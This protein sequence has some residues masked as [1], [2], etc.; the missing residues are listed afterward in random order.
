MSLFQ[1]SS[2][3]PIQIASVPFVHVP[4]V[5]GIT[6]CP[7]KKD[8]VKWERDLD[9]DLDAIEE[10]GASAIV[11][12]LEDHEF[13]TLHVR[14][15]PAGVA[16]RG[17]T[18]FHLPIEDVSTPSSEF[19]VQ[20]A[21]D[22]AHVIKMIREGSRVLIHC[23][24]GLGRSGMI[25]ASLLIESGEDPETAI[26]RVRSARPGAIETPAQERWVRA[27]SPIDNR[28]RSLAD[29]EDP[30]FPNNYEIPTIVPSQITSEERYRGCLLG[31]A[32]GDALGGPIEFESLEA[33]RRRFGEDGITEFAGESGKITDDTQM[34]LFTAEGCIRSW[35]RM[36]DRGV[37]SPRDVIENSYQRWLATQGEPKKN[38]AWFDD[39]WLMHVP[40]MNHRRA[41]GTTCI[42]ALKARSGENDSKGCGGVMRV[43]P[44]GLWRAG[45]VDSAQ[46]F[47]L[48]SDT[49]KITHGHPSGYLSAGFLA[50]VIS[51]ISAGVGLN[52]SIKHAVG[53]LITQRGHEEV[54]GAINA[55]RELALLGN[56]TAEGVESLGEGWVAEEALAIGL[57]CSL[58]ANSFESGV[59]LAVNHSGDSDSTGSI[60][61]QILGAMV[62]VASIPDKWLGKLEL[63]DTIDVISRDLHSISPGNSYPLSATALQH[64]YPP[65]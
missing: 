23:R 16:S 9:T 58:V 48:G 36:S 43:A 59:T 28:N 63:Q 31:G 12:L 6:I 18:W 40:E 39:G 62:G 22:G 44:V 53:Y 21:D 17:M 1:S 13:D 30:L 45:G 47:E 7:G 24:G 20:W 29:R 2:S 11:C 61:G 49:A 42:G 25:A 4:G 55:A 34:T 14:D 19:E 10:W 35:H 38:D 60:T 33:I 57:Y 46:I 65:N 8:G 56:P 51:D 5:V 52:A 26:R 32:V 41:P 15:L 50:V 64:R 54:L 27:R 3:S 37:C